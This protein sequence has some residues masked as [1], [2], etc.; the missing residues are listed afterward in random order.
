MSEPLAAQG[1]SV[2]PTVEVAVTALR[3]IAGSWNLDRYDTASII[4]AEEG[5]L[6]AVEW[7]ED[8]L[9]RVGYLIELDEALHELNPRFGIEHWIKTPNPGPFF[10]G[11]S[12]LQMMTG[13]TRR[14]KELLH[15]VRRWSKS[16]GR[17]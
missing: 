1:A 10:A 3:R 8:R 2:R 14:M 5:N 9:A 16:P 4:A 13:N 15:Q 6:T 7:S 17:S 12:P 11:S